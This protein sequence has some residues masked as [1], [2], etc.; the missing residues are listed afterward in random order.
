M[1]SNAH[2]VLEHVFGY[3]QFRGEQQTVIDTLIQGDDALVLMPTGGGKSLCYQIPAL[4]RTGTGVVIS[5][6]IALMQDQVDALKALGVRAAFLNS[7][8][9]HDQARALES[10][11]LQ[12]ELDMLYIAPERLIQPRTLA[13]LKQA[14]IALFAIDEAHCVSQW[15]HDFRNDY[16]QLSLLCLLY[17]SPSPRDRG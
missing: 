2:S 4:V 9:A 12:G 16:L 13:L 17:T 14:E 11:L 8:L 10:A 15:G 3:H 5:P 1:Q 7:T 6:L